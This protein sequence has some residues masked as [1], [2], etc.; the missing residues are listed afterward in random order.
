MTR[1]LTCLLLAFAASIT[2]ADERRLVGYLPYWATT[3][4]EPGMHPGLTD[5][6]LFSGEPRADGSLDATR[7]E[8]IPWNK[9]ATVRAAGV[10]VHLCL[11]GWG[12]S[13]HFAVVTGEARLR[14]R[15]VAETA[16]FCA[17][18]GLDGVDLDWEHP[19]GA[20]QLAAY[21]K[22]VDELKAALAARKGEVTL[23]LAGAAQLPPDGGRRADRVQ[24]MAYDLPG[25]H[26]T[27]EASVAR[28]EALLAA[29]VPPERLVLGVPFY[30]RGVTDRNRTLP[31]REI[32]ARHRPKPDQDD[33]DG[34]HFNGPVTMARKAAWVRQRGLAGMMAWE[35]TQD[36][37]GEASLLRVLRA[38][39]DRP[40]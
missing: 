13:K 5:L 28:A 32:L 1:T 21:G 14:G 35:L 6:I 39:L 7:L 15:F 33:A 38:E 10:R 34:L 4:I 3:K 26:A 37:P 20:A 8:G 40:R 23:T 36:A 30:G 12:R 17:N 22:L 11:G 31:F 29:G 24:L 25:R 2:A 16:A 27:M 9:V 18:R 19:K